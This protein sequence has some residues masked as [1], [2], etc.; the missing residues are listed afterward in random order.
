MGPDQER[1]TYHSLSS[2][3]PSSGFSVR[4]SVRLYVRLA[5]WLGGLEAWLGGW[6]DKHTDAWMYRQM[7]GW[8]IFSFYRTLFAIKA[9]AQKLAKLVQKAQKHV[10]DD[11]F[12]SPIQEPLP[13]MLHI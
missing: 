13:L 5:G 12:P 6:E 3:R 9:A 7:D 4:L 2:L 8:N 10:T 11:A 1:L